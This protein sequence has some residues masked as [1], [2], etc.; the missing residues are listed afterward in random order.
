M[1]VGLKDLR[2][3]D[4]QCEF[5]E[6]DPGGMMTAALMRGA[7][8]VLKHRMASLPLDQRPAWSEGLSAAQREDLLGSAMDLDMQ[9]AKGST[10]DLVKASLMELSK[11]SQ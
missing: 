11:G 8:G 4:A 2:G 9:T 7:A 10:L 3:E 6:S 1:E 5:T